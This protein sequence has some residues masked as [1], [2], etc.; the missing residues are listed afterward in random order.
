MWIFL[1]ASGCVDP[2]EESEVTLSPGIVPTVYTGRWRGAGGSA[3][4]IEHRRQGSRVQVV[5]P[6]EPPPELPSLEILADD[7]VDDPGLRF[8]SVVVR[9]RSWAVIYDADGALVWWY[10]LP[11]TERIITRVRRAA[12]GDRVLLSV[13]RSVAHGGS[14]P[15][16]ILSV[17]WTGEGPRLLQV[18]VLHHDFA[19][20]PD[21][22]LAWLGIET[23][24]VDGLRLEGDTIERTDG[25]GLQVFWSSWDHF[26]PSRF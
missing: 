2:G 8:T 9:G 18:P 15:F 16:G 12:S 13:A 5:T 24:E 19:E 25:E 22:E 6:S 14:E 26:D 10:E 21:G 11:Y 20:L 17:P 7:E 1:V 23:R 3:A 4:R